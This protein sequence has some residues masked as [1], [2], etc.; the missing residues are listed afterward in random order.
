MKPIAEIKDYD[1][2]DNRLLQYV[3]DY[4]N[5]NSNHKT[6][7][8]QATLLTKVDVGYILKVKKYLKM[9]DCITNE[10]IEYYFGN[11]KIINNVLLGFKVNEIVRKIKNKK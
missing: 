9:G 10:D 11:E 1:C 8:G 3:V 7:Y 2:R 5:K 6:F 4:M